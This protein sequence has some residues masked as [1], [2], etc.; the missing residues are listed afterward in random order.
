MKK[1][2]VAALLAGAALGLAGV[3]VTV[4]LAR[5]EGREA[6]RRLL[7]K[8]EP[9]AKRAREAGEHVVKTTTEQYHAMAPQAVEK[10]SGVLPR[11]APNGK[12]ASAEV[13]A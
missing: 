1:A 10:L 2:Q 7:A 6:A 13:T 4:V 11:L 8:T 5:H 12:K 3:T 9:M